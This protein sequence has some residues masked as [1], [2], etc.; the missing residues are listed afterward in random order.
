MIIDTHLDELFS[1]ISKDDK[2]DS[3][4]QLIWHIVTHMSSL[5]SLHQ[6][7]EYWDTIILHLAKGK[8]EYTEQRDWQNY[9]KDRTPRNMPKLEE[10]IK[11]ITGQ[12]VVIQ[13]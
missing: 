11:F 13:G 7:V 6:P 5:K 9:L 12:N 1:I 10:F 2:A 8:L 4:R 3:M